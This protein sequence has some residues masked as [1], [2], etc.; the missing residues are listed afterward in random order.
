[1]TIGI[2]ECAIWP[3]NARRRS[4][5]TPPV[6]RAASQNV[7]ATTA[8]NTNNP[9]VRSNVAVSVDDVCAST[10]LPYW[11]IAEKLSNAVDPSSTASTA[12]VPGRTGSDGR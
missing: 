3:G 12:T 1:M 11:G 6:V 9:A 7:V 2:N 8:A 10:K 5:S 4:A